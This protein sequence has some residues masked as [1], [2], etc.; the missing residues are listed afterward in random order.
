MDAQL[1]FARKIFAKVEGPLTGQL[2]NGN[3]HT[4]LNNN[5]G[6]SCITLY[7]FKKFDCGVCKRNKQ[8]PD[9][10]RAC[11]DGFGNLSV[12]RPRLARALRRP[13][14]LGVRPA[15]RRAGI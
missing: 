10:T 8:P 9:G 1:E 14:R 5:A 11:G 12:P 4:V 7:N 3:L 2:V 6:V 13:P 15:I